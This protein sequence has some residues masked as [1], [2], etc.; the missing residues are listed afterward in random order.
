MTWEVVMRVKFVQS[1]GVVGATRGCEL[2]SSSLPPDEARELE[3][4]VRAS[5]LPAAGRF[6]SPAARDLRLYE[7]LVESEAGSVAVT[8]D[9]GTLPEQARPLVS[10]L[11][12]NA[13]PRG[14][15]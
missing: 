13:T 15:E 8:F 11:R 5:G 6:L 12:R 7:I 2:D 1:G 4:L 14:R 10:F 9:D 3:S